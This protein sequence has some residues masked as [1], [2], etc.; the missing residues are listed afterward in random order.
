M[1][2]MLFPGWT[3]VLPF[4]LW[5][6]AGSCTNESPVI[7][8]TADPH[9]FARPDE[10]KITHLDLDIVVDFEKEILEGTALLSIEK[11]SR[12]ADDLYLDVKDMDI[13][14]VAISS[15]G[16]EEQVAKF[17][18]GEP[19][20]IL[21]QSLIVPLRQN[22]K[23]VSIVYST[24][25]GAEALQFL[26]K[27]LTADKLAPFLLTQS[28]AI[29]ARTW[30][31]IQDS[32]GIR[33]TYN[34]TVKVPDGLMAVMSAQNPTE[35]IPGGVYS[36]EMSQPVPA[37][38]M[39]LAVGKFAFKSVG[40]RTGIYAEP[41]VL[42]AAAW[43]F[44]E[45]EQMMTIA[46]EM[47]G[48]YQ[49][50]RYD[51]IVLPPSFPFGGMENPRVTFVTPTVIT[52]DRSL[53]ALIA[54]ELAHSWSGNL[55]TNA[56]WND[57]WLNEGFTVYFE[58]RI[59]EKLKGREYSEMLAQISYEDLEDEVQ[60]L[61]PQDS[62]LTRL[63]VDLSGRNPDDGVGSI[64]YDKGYFFLRLIEENV[65]REAFDVFLKNY[66]EE[67]A[68]Q[69]MTTDHFV[70]LLQKDL[71]SKYPGMEVTIRLN[72]WIYGA[73]IPENIPYKPSAQ[74]KLV[75]DQVAAWIAGISPDKLT[76]T[77][78]TSHEWQHF[79]RSLP[80]SL[81]ANEMA[82]LDSVFSFTRSKNPEVQ[83]IWYV[84]S[85]R[86]QY[87]QAYPAIQAFLNKIGRRKFLDPIYREMVKTEEGKIRAREIYREARK[88][89]HPI[90][91]TTIDVILDY[92]EE[93]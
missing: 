63:A 75:E 13:H 7:K 74:F 61:W 41:G 11:V 53:V 35:T 17:T 55:V 31:P 92:H 45:V 19:D 73:G 80:D 59:M 86:Y 89:Y 69:T 42:E 60:G 15:D 88:N 38:L 44:A 34:A 77:G 76:T 46:E 9:S 87:S 3:K 20:S 2:I 93:I 6:A 25:P 65:G 24:H 47:Y 40:E 62:N 23:F 72:E 57:F 22:T 68:F 39:A 49:W 81:S 30:I 29:N 21:G 82:L 4:V 64:A 18:F 5:L 50:E 58:N 54:H 52:G 12:S 1:K 71:L 14:S 83:C 78:W 33:F 56:T 43:E 85:I 28:Q 84:K 10:V 51:L 37:Y 70:S 27:E 66:F 16:K 91:V 67:N 32:P 79:I 48:P 36:F 8:I 90:A 26:P